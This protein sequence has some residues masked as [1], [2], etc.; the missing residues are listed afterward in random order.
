VA[1]DNAAASPNHRSFFVPSAGSPADHTFAFKFLEVKSPE[2]ESVSVSGVTES[3]ALL[4]AR[5]NPE[6]SETTYRVEYTT[7]PSGF[8]GAVLAA[9]GTLAAGL[10][11]VP[12]SVPVA[13]L[14]AGTTYRFRVV[15][16]NEAGS[17]EEEASFR[18]YTPPG[19]GGPCAND[20]L[21]AGPSAKLPDCRAYELV[22]PADTNGRSPRGGAV[23]AG[24][25]FPTLLAS[26]EGDKATFLIDGGTIPGLGGS[27]GAN[28]DNYLS[29]RGSTGWSTEL[30][31][32]S[33]SEV[34][35][36]SPGGFSPDQEHSLWGTFLSKGGGK[37]AAETYIR[38][39]DGHSE[40]VGRGSLGVDREVDAKLIAAEGSHTIFEGGDVKLEPEAP[41]AGTRAV[42]D[43]TADEVT[44]VVSLLP[45]DVTPAAGQN[46][47]YLGA[48]LDGAGVAFQIGSTLY[49][50]R[51]NEQTYQIGSGVA[52]AGL[53]EG[54][55]RIFYLQGGD[56]FAFDTATE[57]AIRFSEGGEA[58]PVNVAADGTV[59]YFLSPDVLS[60][61]ANPDGAL[62]Q[63]GEENLYFSR[64]GEIEFVGTVEE[65]DVEE[66]IT[67]TTGRFAGLGMWD[68]SLELFAAIATSRATPDGNVLLFES[69]AALAGYDP[70]GHTEVYRYDSGAGTLACLSCNPTGAA[71]GGE[72]SLQTLS[73]AV[74]TFSI[75]NL[76]IRVQN[77]R[78]D[79][80]R[81]FFQS[82]EPLVLADTDA[83]QDV[84]EWEAQGVGSCSRPGGCIYLISSGQSERDDHLFAVS[85]S[86]ADAFFLSG[87]LLAGSDT[88]AT[89]SIYDA[90]V[91]GGFPAAE[92]SAPCEGEGCRPAPSPA[93]SLAAT[94]NLFPAKSGN[95]ATRHRCGK[96]KR[97]VSKG[98]KTRCVR[99][100][101]SHK[102]RGHHRAGAKR[103][104]QR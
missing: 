30:A 92:A 7:Q 63:A 76:A 14:Q 33:G 9:E 53:A 96:G 101:R 84:Y 71:A 42:Y 87:D 31:S 21:R 86:G 103:R 10:A 48:S 44:H 90:R 77:L 45:G 61:G 66:E 73:Q 8:E 6:G 75:L 94:E 88:D 98:G 39:P 54:G 36:P 91:E 24:R 58:R 3:E 49:L 4:K 80:R 55:G 99:K 57:T 56:L 12:V 60:A 46:A 29:R 89:P 85:A 41:P 62:P 64:E 26:P 52:F 22:S 50:R 82:E 65:A 47:R 100:H 18:T 38:Y 2:V 97:R 81:A 32:P 74:P 102:P 27:G 72:A 1:V 83:R 69:R 93:P 19:L 16:E 13:G 59:A 17:D 104:G 23:D 35:Q 28:G 78:A 67:G 51:D 95:L 20:A 5:I 15:A 79:G 68:P 70:Q 43:R 40:P 25:Y 11:A 34:A 37:L